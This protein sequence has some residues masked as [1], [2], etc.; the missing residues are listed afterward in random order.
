M[1][2]GDTSRRRRLRNGQITNVDL[3]A[4]GANHDLATGVGARVVLFKSATSTSNVPASGTATIPTQ[5]SGA[6][7]DPGQ[8]QGMADEGKGAKDEGSTPPEPPAA[9][10]AVA[11]AKADEPTVDVAKAVEDAVA[12]AM[13]DANNKI[14][15]LEK[16]RDQLL[17]AAA[18]RVYTEKATEYVGVADPDE[19]KTV[20]KSAAAAG[21][22]AYD[23]LCSVLGKAAE[24]L[25]VAGGLT[26]ELGTT[27]TAAA[28]P[29]V[30]GVT[31]GKAGE[32]FDAL[33]RQ[34]SEA[35]KIHYGEAVEKAM[36]QRPDLFAKYRNPNGAARQ[37]VGPYGS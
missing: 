28:A 11:T 14:A 25:N 4:M 9:P 33:V 29:T 8:E 16:S 23:A 1:R 15:E 24:R 22:E 7:A 13:A 17:D 3:V 21:P 5:T 35:E 34:I 19:L 32:D 30:P 36:H 26:A 20:L 10:A 31:L 6:P 12:K 27:G 37:I 2:P 18:D